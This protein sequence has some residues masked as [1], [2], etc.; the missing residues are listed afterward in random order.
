MYLFILEEVEDIHCLKQGSGNY[1]LTQPVL[2]N[3]IFL[4]HSHTQLVYILSVA[5]LS[6]NGRVEKLLQR[7]YGPQ[8]LKCLL[9]GPFQKKLANLS[10]RDKLEKL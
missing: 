2:V 1:S 8:S 5:A 6:Y 9:S 4:E 10:A 7:Q 3:K